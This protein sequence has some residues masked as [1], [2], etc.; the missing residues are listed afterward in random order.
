[1]NPSHRGEGCNKFY[2]HGERSD[3]TVL[4]TCPLAEGLLD[5]SQASSLTVFI[6]LLG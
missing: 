3:R 5:L 1:M 2:T 6:Q 4:V